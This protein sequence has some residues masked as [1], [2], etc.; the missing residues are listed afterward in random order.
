MTKLYSYHVFLFPFQWQFAGKEMKDKKLEERTCLE[1]FVN[2]FDGTNWSRSKYKTDTI[3]NYNEYNYFY[4][5]VRDVLFDEGEKLDSAIVANLNYNIEPDAYTYNF[6]VSNGNKPISYALHIDAIILHLYS[7]GVG[8]LSFHLNNRKKEQ[9]SEEHILN[10]NQ[11]GRRLYPPFFGIAA[12]LTSTQEKFK[13]RDFENGLNITKFSELAIEFSNIND[14]NYENFEAYHHSD[15]FAYN[16]FQLPNHI[17]FLFDGI[18]VT[19]DKGDFKSKTRKVFINPLLDDRMFVLCW[20]GNNEKSNALNKSFKEAQKDKKDK[21]DKEDKEDKEDKLIREWW[22]RFMYND[23]KSSTCQNEELQEKLIKESTYLRWSNYGT[24]Y[25]IT[26]YSFVCLTNDL[27]TLEKNNVHFIVNHMQTI[28]YKLCELCLVQRACLLR[29]SD[30]VARI[31]RMKD[32]QKLSLTTRVR[33]LYQQYLRFVNRIYFREVTAQEQGIELYE[34]LQNAMKIKSNVEDLDREIQELHTYTT[35]IQD[36]KQN[37]NIEVLT[38]IGA[39]FILPSFVTGFFG[40]NIFAQASQKPEWWRSAI[41]L[42]PLII[43][44]IIYFLLNRKRNK[45]YLRWLIVFSIGVVALIG[46]LL[47]AV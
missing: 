18:P 46:L 44:P 19:V 3:L 10:I 31:S 14:L 36:Q 41:F 1:K 38:I 37:D 25:G 21:K 35:M 16:P 32:D 27:D 30:E 9:S 17:K 23:Q 47:L 13:C 24:I 45:K 20:Y 29:F 39:L 42:I 12:N 11:A 33:N 4:S 34:Y 8:V 40:M 28:Y 26:R 2:M 5:M 7:T 6:K 43:G 22:Y 15:Y